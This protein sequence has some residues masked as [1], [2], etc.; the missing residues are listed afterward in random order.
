M[1]TGLGEGPGCGRGA[2]GRQGGHRTRLGTGACQPPARPA[3]SVSPRR[4]HSRAPTRHHRPGPAHSSPL[5]QLPHEAH[6]FGRFE[7]LGEEGV[8]ADIQPG[9][10]L[11]RGAGTDDGERKV[12]GARIG[13]KPGR[14]AE[15]VQAGHDDIEGDDIGPHL[16]ND[17]QTLGT[18]SRGHHLETLQLEIDPDQLPDDLVVVH[19][20]H[21]TRRAWHNSRVGRDRPPRPGFP[22]FRPER[23]WAGCGAVRW[24]GVG[25]G[26]VAGRRRWEQ[27]QGARADNSKVAAGVQG[28]VTPRSTSENPFMNTLDQLV[29]FYPSQRPQRSG[30][31]PVAQGIEQRP[32]EPCAQVRILPGAP[33]I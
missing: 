23:G 7:G 2:P 1:R 5:G 27:R 4:E 26:G 17:I 22:H 11:V 15:P 31:A 30:H 12:T 20:K 18:V 32:P 21:P 33:E 13:P 10:D 3:R 29:G 24:G 14:G 16:M 28:G 6:E 19:N 9:L 8:D 25:C